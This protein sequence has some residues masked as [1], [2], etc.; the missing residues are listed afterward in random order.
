MYDGL[1]YYDLHGLKVDAVSTAT[2]H[3]RNTTESARRFLPNTTVVMFLAI[4]SLLFCC[5]G[6]TAHDIN[7]LSLYNA[8]CPIA[9]QVEKVTY[10]D[11]ACNDL[12][13]MG[14]EGAV[15]FAE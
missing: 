1:P 15:S 6:A 2:A 9:T 13:S 5:Y 14:W 11:G 10:T 7:T 4:F 8:Y 12:I 3:T